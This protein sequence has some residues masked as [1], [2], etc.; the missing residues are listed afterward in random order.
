M[1]NIKLT[2]GKY[3]IVD[4]EDYPYLNRLKWHCLRIKGI[5]YFFN[6]PATT[7]MSVNKKRNIQ[8]PMVGL[9]VRIKPNMVVI[10]KNKNSLDCRKKNLFQTLKGG[11][12]HFSRK[13]KGTYS[14]FRGVHWDK[15]NGSWRSRI[16]KDYK[17]YF[18][19]YSQNEKILAKKYNKKARELYGEFAYQNKI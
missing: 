17:N 7:L 2:Q 18:L 3:A 5:G 15:K 11:K 19:G 13:I 8:F 6:I 1:K 14:K 9:L 12:V 4:D 16:M 10:Y